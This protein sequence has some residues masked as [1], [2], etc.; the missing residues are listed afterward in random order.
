[1]SRFC[2]TYHDLPDDGFGD[3]HIPDDPLHI[4]HH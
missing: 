2:E 1:M 4:E 3:V